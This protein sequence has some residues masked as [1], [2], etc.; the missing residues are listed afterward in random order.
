MFNPPTGVTNGAEYTYGA[1]TWRFD[2]TGG[3]WNIKDGTIVGAAGPAGAQGMTGPTGATGGGTTGD[4]GALTF[5]DSTGRITARVTSAV[6]A[7]GVASF[8]NT[9]FLVDGTGHVQLAAAYQVTGD[10]V[11]AGSFINIG[12]GK[13]IN[14]IGVQSINGVTGPFSITGPRHGVLFLQPNLGVAAAGISANSTLVF[15][16]TSLTFGSST[17]QVTITGPSMVL[18]DVMTI[19][20]GVFNN[21]G[22]RSQHWTL[23]AGVNT[24]VINGL[25]GSIQRFTVQ[26]NATMN[27]VAGSGWRNLTTATETIAVIVQNKSTMTA[28]FDSTI[29]VDG[30]GAPSLFGR[31]TIATRGVTGGISVFTLMRVQKGSGAL[32]MGFVIA[33]GMTAPNTTIN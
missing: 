26:P 29:L 17:S 11:Q 23:G 22:E 5:F 28:A 20:G 12:T 13:T 8:R 14:N 15:N 9:H 7:T 33:T 19:T 1:I 21:P 24:L 16:G 27:I 25:S 6:G 3:V 18:G 2:G 31:D 32:N 4:G 10:T 30:G